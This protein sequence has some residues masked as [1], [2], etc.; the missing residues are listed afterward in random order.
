N[1]VFVSEN[2]SCDHYCASYGQYLL[3]S[4]ERILEE[5]AKEN[6]KKIIDRIRDQSNRLI[7][8][9]RE[10]F[11]QFLIRQRSTVRLNLMIEFLRVTQS[12]EGLTREQLPQSWLCDKQ[13]KNIPL[14]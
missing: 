4:L 1:N 6:L 10:A 3:Y 13:D 8:I 7:H 12:L 2:E 9:Q 11:N 5:S 14:I